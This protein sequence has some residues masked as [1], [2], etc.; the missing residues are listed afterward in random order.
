MATQQ[1]VI[2]KLMA[3]LD[4]TGLKGIEALDAAI[5]ACSNFSNF[6]DLKTKLV[7]D[8]KSVGNSETFLRDYCGII[9]NNDDTGA[10]TGSD[11]GGGIVKTA[12]S[13]V[14]E[15][16]DLKNFTSDEFTIDGLNVKLGKGG[17]TGKVES[18]NFSNLS[19]QEKYIWQSLYSYWL[20]S[21]LKLVGES[22]G[23]NFS[24]NDKS[25]AVTKTLYIIFD[26]TNDNILASTRGGTSNAKKSANDMELHINLKFYGAATGEDGIPDNDQSYLDRIIAHELTHA[27]MR[28]NID[29]F[30]Y[31][32]KWFKEGMAELTHG[33]D[34]KR[35]SDIQKLAG[36]SYSLQRIFSDVSISGVK[37]PS[38]SGG[39]IALRYLAKQASDTYIKN[40]IGTDADE[41]FETRND[42]ITISGGKGNDTI[43]NYGE[44][45]LINYAAGDGNDLIQGFNATSTLNISGGAYSTITNGSDLILKVGEG[46]ITLENA[47]GLKTLNIDGEEDS[48]TMILN[49]SSSSKV[50]PGAD[51]EVIDASNRTKAIKIVGN[52]LDNSIF[53]GS[54]KDTLYGKNGNDYLF[55]DA[56]NDKLYGQNGNDTLYGGTGND[57]LTGGKG[58]DLFICDSG[59]DIITDY[60]TGDKISVNAEIAASSVVGSDAT[61]TIG[62][63]TLTVTNGKNKEIEFVEANGTT[64]TIIGGAYLSTD[65]T[66]DK[67]TL[68]AKWREVADASTRTKAVN[69]TGNAQNNSILGGSGKDTIYGKDGD[70]YLVGNAGADKLY[71]Q[72]GNDTLWGGIGN[73]TLTGGAG[74]DTFIYNSGEGKDVIAD[75][76]D[77]DL[78]QITG[79]FS[80]TY[81]E[82]KN[83]NL[84]MPKP[85]MQMIL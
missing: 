81:N 63:N 46:L 45:I 11:A 6:Q 78:L 32:P 54:G 49:N 58:N 5:K 65:K 7:N 40:F 35:T 80:A 73:D 79:T 61:F 51:I 64:R 74:A 17:G 34:D 19:A 47:V 43:T 26:N 3:T 13:I 16:G 36:N 27:V 44:K 37:A 76:G 21:G 83:T 57:T 50:T 42:F 84:T 4:T 15:N 85:P 72:N 8:C 22:Y 75:F 12:K 82:S 14:P 69:I 68:T 31:L 20:K 62:S 48:S 10:I 33:I 28:A 66:A 30:D 60:A 71:G 55:G 77:D 39:Y 9:L 52:A 41:Q 2:R 67:V 53:G 24:F 56:G 70:D 25:S 23:E 18:R 38:Y 1:E 29:Y 59:N